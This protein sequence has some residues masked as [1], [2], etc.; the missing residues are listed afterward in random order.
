M[1][2]HVLLILTMLSTTTCVFGKSK[3]TEVVDGIEWHYTIEGDEAII[4]ANGAG[5]Y[6]LTNNV[7]GDIVV[8]DYLG[9]V[10]VR[11]IGRAAF[12]N[13][14]A[15]SSVQISS[16]VYHISDYAFYDC[17]NL[18]TVSL[19][20]T[21]TNIGFCAFSGCTSLTNI[22]VP[23][24][25]QKISAS[26][27]DRCTE[28]QSVELPSTIETIEKFAFSRCRKLKNI[29]LPEGLKQIKVRA[30]AWC[31]SLSNINIP[32]SVTN[33][34]AGAF[35]QC[36]SL[37]SITIPSGVLSLGEKNCQG[38]FQMCT[39]LSSI[40]FNEGL[41]NL[42]GGICDLC[43]KLKEI[44]LPDSITNIGSRAFVNGSLEKIVIGREVQSVGTAAFANNGRLTSVEFRGDAPQFGQYV[45]SGL[46]LGGILGDDTPTNCVFRIHRGT[47]G[48][49][50][51]EPNSTNE[52]PRIQFD[53]CS[54]PVEYVDD[55]LED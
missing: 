7:Q 45:F 29:I 50:I 55:A 20:S 33:I 24:G 9:G 14:N 17:T 6:A 3:L 53:G 27:F 39:S 12:G 2:K 8:P 23:E 19:P 21:L 13:V 44:V 31:E 15:I 54:F 36:R 4:G 1:N 25:I 46:V 38:V 35:V 30:F 49:N 42:P 28:L 11:K 26:L 48:W 18:T 22:V 40:T 10:R 43:Y 52:S 16:G 5:M 34:E 47:T 41:K 51:I 32:S 37:K